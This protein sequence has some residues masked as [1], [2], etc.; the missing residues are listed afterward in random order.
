MWRSGLEAFVFEP[1]I[2]SF[3]LSELEGAINEARGFLLKISTRVQRQLLT[4]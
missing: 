4:T 3:L 2:G 1:E